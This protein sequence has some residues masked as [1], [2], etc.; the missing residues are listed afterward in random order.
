[1]TRFLLLYITDTGCQCDRE[2]GHILVE[3]AVNGKLLKTAQCI[4]CA[5]GSMPSKDQMKCQPCLYNPILKNI[6]QSCNCTLI[7]GLCLP[8]NYKSDLP[9]R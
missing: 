1:M 3:R 9:Y 5:P 2:N 8:V 4:K 7:G 6:N